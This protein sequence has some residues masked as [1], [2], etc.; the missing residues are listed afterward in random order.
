MFNIY[1]VEYQSLN[2]LNFIKSEGIYDL[3][4]TTFESL[5]GKAKYPFT[6]TDRHD[7]RLD[8]VSKDIYG[9]MD[10][11]D[12]LMYINNIYVEFSVQS[13]DTIFFIDPSQIQSLISKDANIKQVQQ[14]LKAANAG[15]TFKIDPTRTKDKSAK[16]TTEQSK[17]FIPP[18]NILLQVNKNVEIGLTQIIINPS[19]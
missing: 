13:G 14:N 8:L 18:N 17:K 16:S 5:D 4:V 10:F 12:L 15:K 6:L 11:V 1:N 7:G 3:Y 9:T 19:F 2:N